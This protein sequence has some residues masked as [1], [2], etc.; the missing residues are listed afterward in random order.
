[1]LDL[2]EI[3]LTAEDKYKLKQLCETKNK[4]I[5]YKEALALI[6]VNRDINE[7]GTPSK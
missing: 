2:H 5:K 1:M 3:Q 4:Q 6:T 7:D